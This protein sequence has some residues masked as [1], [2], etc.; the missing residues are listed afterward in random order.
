MVAVARRTYRLAQTRDKEAVAEYTADLSDACAA[1]HG[2]YRD[3]GGRGRGRGNA[4]GGG[5]SARCTHR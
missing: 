2:V 4:P 5:V 1:C 3:V